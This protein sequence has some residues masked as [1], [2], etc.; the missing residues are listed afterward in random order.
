MADAALRI[1]ST[2]G[3]EATAAAAYA[4]EI[5]DLLFGLLG[6][7]IQLRQPEIEPVLRGAIGIPQGRHDLLLKTLQAWGIGFQLTTIAEQNAT[8]RRLRQTERSR[9]AEKVEGTF[10]YVFAEAAA[11]GVKPEAIQALFQQARIRPVITAHPTE[12]KRVT[13]LE[14][15]RRIYLLLVELESAR[16]TPRER[17]MRLDDLRNAIDLLWLTGEL[18]LEKPTVAQEVAWGLHFFEGALFERVPELL[19][20]LHWALAQAYPDQAFNI[21]PFFQFGSWIGGDRDGNP[22][23]TNEVTRGALLANRRASLKRYRMRLERLVQSLSIARHAVEAPEI[24]LK[25]LEET[26]ARAPN[27]QAIAARNPGEVF[28]QFTACMLT[29]LE[30][31]LAE[32]PPAPGS[33]DWV[34]RS[35]DELIHDLQ[36]LEQGLREARCLALAKAMVEPLR[37]EVEV[38]RFRTVRLDLR[39]NTTVTNHTLMALWRQRTGEPPTA[40][41]P[42]DLRSQEWKQWLL[43]ELAR[44]LE[45]LPAFTDLDPQAESTLGMFRLVREV[46]K[47]VDREAFGSFILSMS[48]SVADV[49]GIYLLAKYAG[50]FMDPEGVESC[51]LPVVPLFETIEDLEQ[52]PAILRELLET[53]LVR[54]SLR[55][56]GGV[57]EVMIGY[58]DPNK[59]GG[60]LTSNWE[61]N[62][63]QARLT[64]V[65]EE[66]GIPIAFFHGRGG[67]VSR[68]GV[69]TGRAIAAQPAGSVHGQMRITEQG[70][71]VSLKYANRGTAQYHMELLAASIFEHTLKSEREPELQPNLEFNEALEALSGAAYA[72]YRRLVEHPGLMQYYQAASPVEELVLLNI[73]S[74]PARRFGAKSL[75]DLRAIP[76][77][78]AWT[79][80]R[81]MVPGWYGVGSGLESFIKVRGKAGEQLLK[82]MFHKSRLFRL[83]IDEVEKTL[84]QVDLAIA[85]EYA[86]LVPETTIRDEIFTM[87]EEEYHRTVTMVLRVSS[88]QELCERFPRHRRRLARRL[89]IIDQVGREQVKLIAQFRAKAPAGESKFG[90]DLVPLLLS[91]NCIA[92]GL[93]WTG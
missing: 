79:Q 29:K 52:A 71:V 9:G 85:R 61:L 93:G 26:L 76:W 24:F 69:P 51:T 92:S 16:W 28:R 68:G 88:G 89:P 10:A 83:I 42:P 1:P 14:I 45:G 41:H 20:K 84:P 40:S 64:R 8:M 35:A 91:I 11:A 6:D 48:R 7:V 18:R 60:F 4:Q 25:A 59:D 57:Q 55:D 12:A 54:R 2:E 87:I 39:E 82:Q 17:E 37:R 19:E 86:A 33:E 34:Y 74:R 15:H 22:F 32:R 81:H 47:E 73:G 62:K 50:L 70:E 30:G 36:T 63:A 46:R 56:L 66:C 49:L 5:L 44:P 80:N 43:S 27:G 72:A 23:V 3:A 38:F 21:P 75:S 77:V 53:P 67:S 58:S 13:V 65:G 78:F 90:E 31:T